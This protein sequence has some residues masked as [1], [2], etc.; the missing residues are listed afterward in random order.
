MEFLISQYS[1]IFCVWVFF[2]WNNIENCVFQYL[3]IFYQYC[4]YFY[5]FLGKHFQMCVSNY[6]WI[7]VNILVFYWQILEKRCF[8]IFINICS[9]IWQCAEV[10]HHFSF[11]FKKFFKK[12]F[13]NLNTFNCHYLSIC[14]NISIFYW[15]ILEKHCFP[16]FINI[17][18]NIWQCATVFHHFSFI[19]KNSSKKNSQIWTRLIVIIYQYVSIYQYFID[20]YWKTTVFQYL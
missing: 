3:Q 16:I 13:S 20:K 2:Y 14:V 10:F 19:F 17:C 12:N 11:I 9:N 8:P 6:C 5:R 15:Q 7:F 18:S 4:N 1:Q